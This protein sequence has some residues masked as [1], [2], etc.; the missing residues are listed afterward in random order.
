MTYQELN[1]FSKYVFNKVDKDVFV[2]ALKSFIPHVSTSYVDGK[3]GVF[4]EHPMIFIGTFDEGLFNYL[5]NS[6]VEESYKG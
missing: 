4:Q 3:W 6:M 2:V 1:V 5:Y